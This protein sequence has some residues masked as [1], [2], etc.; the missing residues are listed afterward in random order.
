VNIKTFQG[1]FRPLVNRAWEAQSHLLN[2]NVADRSA[3]DTWYRSTL[4]KIIHRNTTSDVDDAEQTVLLKTFAAIAEAEHEVPVIHGWTE[5]QN[6]AFEELV[7]QAWR[8]SGG[9]NDHAFRH[10]LQTETWELGISNWT[11]CGKIGRTLCFDRVMGHLAC[12]ADNGYWLKRTAA[13]EE[14]RLR[15]QIRQ[16]LRDLEE[17]TG[18]TYH[19]SYVR[20]IWKQSAQLP[21]DIMDATVPQLVSVI[22]MLDT[23]VRRMAPK[24]GQDF[25][26]LPSR[27]DALK[28]PAVL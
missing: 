28:E 21:V 7:L 14:I 3:K 26:T 12:I 17:L 16:K 25:R 13:Q 4:E 6:M 27:M 1:R 8:K 10:W 24:L 15:F 9:N 11:A 19:W 18:E 5:A 22:A 23:H 20:S 2:L